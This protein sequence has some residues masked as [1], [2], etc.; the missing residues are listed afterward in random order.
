M[1]FA[2]SVGVAVYLEFL[3]SS[4]DFACFFALSI[5][6]AVYIENY[7]GNPQNSATVQNNRKIKKKLN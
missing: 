6:V 3:I 7:G 2:L 5:E 4:V 1:F